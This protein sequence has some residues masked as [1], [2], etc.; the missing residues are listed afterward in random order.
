[1]NPPIAPAGCLNRP[2]ERSGA[3][4]PLFSREKAPSH[5]GLARRWPS[6][7]QTP[8]PERHSEGLQMQMLDSQMFFAAIMFFV[9]ILWAVAIFF[10]TDLLGLV[11]TIFGA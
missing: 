8:M 5:S 1:M 6:K 3:R 7:R 10:A 2:L 9:A 4:V 11:S